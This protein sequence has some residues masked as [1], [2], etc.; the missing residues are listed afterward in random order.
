MKHIVTLHALVMGS[1]IST[2]NLADNT[3]FQ[4][5]LQN[6]G[7]RCLLTDNAWDKKC[8]VAKKKRS[9]S[10]STVLYN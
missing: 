3:S 5:L 10:S 2:R 1:W 4:S 9:L 8:F 7:T 6:R